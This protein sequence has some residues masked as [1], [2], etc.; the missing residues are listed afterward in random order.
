MLL[1][2]LGKQKSAGLDIAG[3]TKI[4][5]SQ[6]L[7]VAKLTKPLEIEIVKEATLSP[8]DKTSELKVAKDITKSG[9]FGF[10]KVLVPLLLLAAAGY[11]FKD[12]ILVFINSYRGNATIT[13]QETTIFD[14]SAQ[15]QLV[16]E[17]YA[18]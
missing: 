9:N 16:A 15:E 1:G 18:V 12:V 2:L 8:I 7:A 5:E 6:A 3:F 4:F 17:R 14:E 11:F 13:T 10:L